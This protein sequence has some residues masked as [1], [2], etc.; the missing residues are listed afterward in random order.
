MIATAYIAVISHATT[1][2]HTA[3]IAL[4]LLIRSAA[5]MFHSTIKN[6]A[7][8]MFHSTTVKHAAAMFHSTIILAKL[9]IVQ[10]TTVK[11]AAV[12]YHSTTTSMYANQHAN[13]HAIHVVMDVN[14]V[15]ICQ[16]GRRFLP[17]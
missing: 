3:N 17:V 8:V 2:K 7:A 1:T 9:N 13:Q 6:N 12:G 16:T 10:S 15:A 14:H 11:N 5:A 4:R